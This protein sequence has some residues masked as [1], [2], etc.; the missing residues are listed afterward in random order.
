M[1]HPET[2]KFVNILYAHSLLPTIKNPT[3]ITDHDATLFD[4][5]FTSMF[6]DNQLSSI[7]IDDHLPVFY[8]NRENIIKLK[9]TE[10]VYKNM[11]QI[12]EEN[13]SNFSLKLQ[14]TDWCI[15][16]FDVNTM[17][18]AFSNKFSTTYNEIMPI[19]TKRIKLYHNKYKPWITHS[20]G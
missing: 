9:T 17:Y 11:R 12:N 14:N 16:Y 7:I 20:V 4:N 10:C 18:N 3:R 1:F 15:E 13:L 5:I 6:D 2:D 19:K 8:I